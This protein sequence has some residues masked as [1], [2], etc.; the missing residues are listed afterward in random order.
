M[1][2]KKKPPINDV[3][4]V[5]ASSVRPVH[6][7]AKM[8][9]SPYRRWRAGVD[10]GLYLKYASTLAEIFRTEAVISI[11]S[12]LVAAII[13]LSI[14]LAQPIDLIVAVK[15]APG[16]SILTPIIGLLIVI[17]LLFPTPLPAVVIGLAIASLVVLANV[18][19]GQ[20]VN[21]F[22][23]TL[24][25]LTAFVGGTAVLTRVF[26]AALTHHIRSSFGHK[27]DKRPGSDTLSL[28]FKQA[29]KVTDRV[30]KV[31]DNCLSAEQIGR[32]EAIVDDREA[33]YRV[34]KNFLPIGPL[35]FRRPRAYLGPQLSVN[36]DA[37]RTYRKVIDITDALCAGVLGLIGARP[38]LRYSEDTDK[39]LATDRYWR[40]DGQEL[41]D[42]GFNDVF[43]HYHQ[44]TVEADFP[45]KQRPGDV[46]TYKTYACISNFRRRP[47]Y[48]LRVRDVIDV[49]RCCHDAIS[50]E[51]QLRIYEGL[52]I[53]GERAF[54]LLQVGKFAKHSARADRYQYESSEPLG[55][56]IIATGA[57]DSDVIM[58][59]DAGRVWPRPDADRASYDAVLAL[60]RAIDLASS[61]LAIELTL[62]RQD[63][64][65]IDNLRML[66]GRREDS[67]TGLGLRLV[68]D[69]FAAYNPSV[70][71]RWTRQLY[72][73]PKRILGISKDI[74]DQRELGGNDNGDIALNLP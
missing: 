55:K 50:E 66:M 12:S 21:D 60:R 5:V 72:G 63:V 22:D 30:A 41:N 32:I 35:F 33:P 27:D 64:L 73:Y 13:A 45:P 34:I 62:L 16:S 40:A 59:F 9:I 24:L 17:S 14:V 4:Y 11:G 46:S 39:P 7:H 28:N 31:L 53:D 43:L 67:P 1:F 71:G 52:S 29:E 10:V 19:D 44:S 3:R 6:R 23:F 48:L 54:E 15:S 69:C 26:S 2:F 58:A 65:L 74:D 20:S 18:S 68:L 70:V 38:Q 42:T 49:L 57:D 51:Q 37:Y 61:T 36:T 56:A 8:L 47:L 25:Q